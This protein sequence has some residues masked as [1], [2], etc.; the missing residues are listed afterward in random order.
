MR[1]RIT[2]HRRGGHH[3]RRAHRREESPCKAVEPG[4][5]GGAY[6]PL[7][8][9]DI[10]RIHH[11]VLDV[12]ENIGM[13]SPIPVLVE[14]ALDKGCRIDG[15]GRLHFPRALVEDVIAEAPKR[16]VSYGRDPDHDLEISGSRVYFDPGGEAVR[17]L[18][19]ETGRYRPS[20]LVD[21]YDFSRLVDRL[22]HVHGFSRVVVATELD[23]LF[24]TDI[25]SLYAS[26]AGTMKHVHVGFA[27][28]AHIDAAVELLELVAGGKDRYR[29]RPFCSTGGCQVVSPLAYGKDNSEVCVAAPKLGPSVSVVIAPQA[30][31]TAPA[32]L[33]GTLVQTVAET[34]GALLLVNLVHP[35]FPV[36]FGPWPFVSDLRTGAF[37][38][39]GGEEAVLSAAAAQIGNYYGLATSVGAGM[40]D[41]KWPDN[42][43]G[44]EKG[45]T[46]ALAALAGA[47]SVSET[48][49]MM[50]SL[51]GCSFEA[52]VIDNDMLGCI[53]RA[54]RGIEVTDETLSYEVIKEVVD[55]PGHYLGHPQTLELMESEYLYPL[56]GDRGSLDEWEEEGRR[57]ILERARQRAC[58]I[59][60][61]HY[62]EYIDARADAAIRQRFPIRLPRE[63]MQPG[64]GRW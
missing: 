41:S 45:I 21:L 31:A 55:G 49:G 56:V 59:L 13:A 5:S 10:E 47:N 24:T 48:A 51:I 32:A 25:N 46:I 17:T 57:D 2:T 42:Q 38:G 19:V 23:D 33:A 8:N 60:S 40:S 29:K 36:S 15:K 4:L 35:G 16:Q 9:R 6:R 61:S 26:I 62:P 22:E 58:A 18:D 27:D 20:T 43:A 63:A 28:A 3:A 44:Y 12:L 39:G 30:G 53:Q 34:L 14:H 37:S 1:D 64:C 50:A 52:M 11:T 7:S 54:L